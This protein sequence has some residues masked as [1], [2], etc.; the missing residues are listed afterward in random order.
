MTFIAVA[1]Q[2][3][4]IDTLPHHPNVETQKP[5]IAAINSDPLIAK[6]WE[7]IAYVGSF[8]LVL[9]VVAIVGIVSRRIEYAILLA[10]SLSV[11]LIAFFL[12]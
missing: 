9:A 11:V 4:F 8:L 6:G 3:Q 12:L 10:L 5:S 1:P 2:V 7:K